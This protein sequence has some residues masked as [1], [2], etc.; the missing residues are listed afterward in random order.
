MKRI[1]VFCGAKTG[2]DP[3]WRDLAEQTGR[4]LARR[5]LGLVYGGGGIGLMGAMAQAAMREGGQVNGIIPRCLIRQEV[6][7]FAISQLEVVDTMAERK[8]LM[9]ARADGFLIL[10][11]GLGTLDELFEVLTLRQIGLHAKPVAVLDLDGY[12]APLRAMLDSFTGAGF[13]M[14][15]H[16]AYVGWHADLASALDQL[17]A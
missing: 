10:P 1:C 5:G 2:H 14:A 17:T 15:E 13:V 4:E 12:F 16:T 7:S 9:I 8:T 11:G 3:R 6:G